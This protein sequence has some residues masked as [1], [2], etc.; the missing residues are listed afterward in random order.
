MSTIALP[1]QS[2]IWRKTMREFVTRIMSARREFGLGNANVNDSARVQ[3]A[4]ALVNQWW[5]SGGILQANCEAAYQPIN[6]ASLAA[7]YINIHNPG[8]YN[9]TPGVAPTWNAIDGWIGNGTQWL[10]TGIL[11]GNGYSVI[12]RFSN[13]TS[14]TRMLFGSTGTGNNFFIIPSTGLAV[15]YRNGALPRIDV[16]PGLLSGS[17][18]IA[19]QQGYR[20][21]VA[22][23]GLLNA[24]TGTWTN[25]IALLARKSGVATVDNIITAYI[26]AV[27]IYNTTITPAEV[28]AVYTAML[29]L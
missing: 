23:G 1:S 13:M 27:A 8:T 21:G 4:I 10:D 6:S 2:L 26:Q 16:V 20:N 19:G 17:L 18:C 25:T 29:A 3:G 15:G 5:L 24:P 9:A 14:N 7:S 12:M 11:I 22:D 28:L